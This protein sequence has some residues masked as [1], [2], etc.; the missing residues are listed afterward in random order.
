MKLEL[1]RSNFAQFSDDLWLTLTQ[2]NVTIDFDIEQ[3][4]LLDFTYHLLSIADDSIRKSKKDTREIEG[5]ISD[6][7][8][9]IYKLNKEN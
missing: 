4:E 8:E 5:K 9:E 3:D 1:R 7:M 6:I 2:D